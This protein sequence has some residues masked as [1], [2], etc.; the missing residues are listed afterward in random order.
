MLNLLEKLKAKKGL[1]STSDSIETQE[2]PEYVNY[3]ATASKFALAH[4]SLLNHSTFQ[5]CSATRAEIT[6]PHTCPQA[7]AN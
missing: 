1:L 4:V 6:V 3:A 7:L 2:H 5:S